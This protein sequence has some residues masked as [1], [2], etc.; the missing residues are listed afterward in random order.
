MPQPPQL[1]VSMPVLVS[2]PSFQLP[3]QSFIPGL[4]VGVH[5]PLLQ[6]VVL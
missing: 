5:L 1:F 3:L 2:Q 4:H 6:L